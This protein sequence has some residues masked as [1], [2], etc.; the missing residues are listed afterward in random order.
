[1]A[2]D[3]TWHPDVAVAQF[4]ENTQ[5]ITDEQTAKEAFK[6]ALVKAFFAGR[7]SVSTEFTLTTERVAEL[8]GSV[9]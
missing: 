9:T 3:W 7:R 2:V 4:W 1:M 6:A 5:Q 8:V